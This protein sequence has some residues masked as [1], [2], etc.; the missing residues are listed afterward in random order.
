MD[1]KMDIETK[2]GKV[3]VTV[4]RPHGRI[5]GST[6]ESLI[7]KTGQ[8]YTNGTRHLL[9]DLGDVNF[10]SSAGLVALHSIILVM[11][12]EHVNNL[13]SGW[14]A[15]HDIDRDTT[16]TQPYVKLLNPQPYSQY[17]QRPQVES[18]SRRPAA[19][20]LPLPRGAPVD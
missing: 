9:L 2:Q 7:Q 15:L 18:L 6:Y 8:L 4:V 20:S 3:P 5:D 14:D 13:E 1:L 11:R 19:G 16:G 17:A 12:G 10:L